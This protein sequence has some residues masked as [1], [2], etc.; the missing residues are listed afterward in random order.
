[1]L[2]T[3]GIWLLTIILSCFFLFVSYK[4]FTGNPVTVGH[5]RE[6]GYASW[7]IIAVACLEFAGAILLLFPITATSGALLLALVVTGATFTLL[8]FKIWNTSFITI[9]A[10]ILL[11]LLGYL[12][13]N[14]SWIL[15]LFKMGKV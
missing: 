11:L 14:Q 7:V 6:W 15:C 8:N 9:T 3:S 13:W 2:K 12:R 5:F 1:M 4:K 10:C